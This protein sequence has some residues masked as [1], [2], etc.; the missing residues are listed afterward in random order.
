MVYWEVGNWTGQ[1]FIGGTPLAPFS[2]VVAPLVTFINGTNPSSPLAYRVGDLC[3]QQVLGPPNVSV[4][5]YATFN[6]VPTNGGAGVRL[7]TTDGNGNFAAGPFP[8]L[9][10]YVGTW[11]A[12]YYV[13]DGGAQVVAPPVTFTVQ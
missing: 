11:V 9:S 6:G 13:G 5:Q 4:Y 3:T 1:F 2:F 12:T 8:M 10:Q 7:G